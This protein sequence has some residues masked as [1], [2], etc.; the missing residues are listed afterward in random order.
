MS[1]NNAMTNKVA[2]PHLLKSYKG[3]R[4]PAVD[5]H[6]YTDKEDWRGL[7]WVMKKGVDLQGFRL[8]MKD[9]M[10]SG[11]ILARLMGYVGENEEDAEDLEIAEYYATRGKLEKVDEDVGDDRCTALYLASRDDYVNIVKGLLAA[12]AN[13]D[14]S[15][16]IGW[17]PLFIAAQNGHIAVAEALLKLGAN[18][19]KAK[20]DGITPLYI[21]AQNGHIAV[22]EALLSAGADWCKKATDGKTARTWPEARATRRSPSC[23]KRPRRRRRL[24]LSSRRRRARVNKLTVSLCSHVHRYSFHTFFTNCQRQRR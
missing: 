19:D 21:A 24:K 23:W 2:R 6:V 10:G 18:K 12:G 13:K 1:L 15:H 7:R 11:T 4:S 9:E 16:A 14:K 22:A 5:Q 20:D 3:M 8:K 17:S